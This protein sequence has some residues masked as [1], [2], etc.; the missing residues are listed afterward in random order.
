MSAFLLLF[1]GLIIAVVLALLECF[2]FKYFR[3]IFGKCETWMCCNLLS[4]DLA[5]SI[6]KPDNDKFE[7]QIQNLTSST[8]NSES[9]KMKKKRKNRIF[10]YTESTENWV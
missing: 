8:T 4:T 3:K 6:K 5:N 1:M 7:E 10:G 2:Y 9:F